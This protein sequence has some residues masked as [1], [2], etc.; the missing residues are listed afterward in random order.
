M[1]PNRS[2]PEMNLPTPES[3]PNVPTPETSPGSTPEAPLQSP[4][5]QSNDAER[6]AE[7]SA[8]AQ[9]AIAAQ[10]TPISLPAPV[11]P[12]ADD[13]QPAVT[14]D[15]PAVAADDDLIE[16][17]WVDKAKEIIG[18]TAGDPAQREKEVSRLQADY[19]KKRYGKELGASTE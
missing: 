18:H 1:E 4:E 2:S 6:G 16:K 15:L 7:Q 8:Q 12:Q 10:P 11:Q 13:A 17:E 3:L 9:A 5:R 19:L 14:D